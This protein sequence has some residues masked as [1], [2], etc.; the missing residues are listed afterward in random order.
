ML[1]VIADAL[2]LIEENRFVQMKNTLFQLLL[3]RLS[4]SALVWGFDEVIVQKI[5]AETTIPVQPRTNI[6][7]TIEIRLSG[8]C[9]VRK[10]LQSINQSEIYTIMCLYL[11]VSPR[12]TPAHGSAAGAA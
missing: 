4:R 12:H 7:Y 3:D 1:V 5:I 11:T 10:N 6:A 8:F 9:R 2:H